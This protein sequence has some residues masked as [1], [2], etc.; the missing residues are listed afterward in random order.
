MSNA[1]SKENENVNR[2]KAAQARVVPDVANGIRNNITRTVNNLMDGAASA[3][4]GVKQ[5]ATL[6]ENALPDMGI[7]LKER[8]AVVKRLA[9]KLKDPSVVSSLTDTEITSL[10]S[11]GPDSKIKPYVKQL[12]AEMAKRRKNEESSTIRSLKDLA[13]GRGM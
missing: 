7:G 4:T 13:S 8:D 12:Q 9:P 2:Q 6:A 1:I 5:L 11:S 10:L 3:K